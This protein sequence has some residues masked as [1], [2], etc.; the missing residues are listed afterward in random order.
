MSC[1]LCKVRKEKRFCP[2]VHDKICPVCCGKEREITLDC[3][4]ECVY[5]QEAR[6]YE[7]SERFS[8]KDVPKEALFP[9][10]E[11]REQFLYEREPLIT[12]LSF[13]LA[14]AVRA[15]RALY[16]RD[17]I[18][19]L[20]TMAS[21]QQ[22]LVNSGLHLGDATASPTQQAIMDGF[23]AM[24]AEYRQMEQK[25]IGYSSLRDRDMLQAIVFLLRIAHGRTS[26]RPRSRAF[27]DF[28]LQQFPEKNESIVAPQSSS[29]VIP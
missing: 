29:I 17:L 22:T 27:A 28:L 14:K 10:V 20:S 2:A 7:R 15:D 1:I 16:D 24:V 8:P 3:P 6:K 25:H 26:G 4:S 21:R 9:E 19:A 11:I 18:A 12:G 13:A 23:E 5:L